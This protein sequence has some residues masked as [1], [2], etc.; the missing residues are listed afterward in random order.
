MYVTKHWNKNNDDPSAWD[1]LN[2]GLAVFANR[3]YI[4]RYL[5]TQT[6]SFSGVA[7]YL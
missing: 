4:N 2:W 1:I 3:Y 7:T 5:I 6:G